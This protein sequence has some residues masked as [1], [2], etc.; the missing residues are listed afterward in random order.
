MGMKRPLLLLIGWLALPS[1]L[2]A[3]PTIARLE[4]FP[5][6]RILHAPNRT[7]QLAVI[8]HFTDGSKRDVTHLTR[9]T[10]TV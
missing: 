8:A 4:V 10:T 9:F 1:S 5:P 7:Q 6:E 3:Q 2:L